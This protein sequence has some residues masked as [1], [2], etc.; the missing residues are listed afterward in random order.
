MNLFMQLF[1]P[2]YPSG[3]M[4]VDFSKLSPPDA[5]AR[6]RN[7]DRIEAV[8]EQM[9]DKYLLAVPVKKKLV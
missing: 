5:E 1:F 9:G 6:Q 7:H 8:K 4:F 2:S 3:G